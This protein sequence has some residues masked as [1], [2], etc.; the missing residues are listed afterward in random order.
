[1]VNL[2]DEVLLYSDPYGV[3]LVISPWN[4]P[5]QLALLPLASAICGGN[6][7]ILKPSEIAIETSKVLANLVPKY[8][9]NVRILDKF[10]P[11]KKT[12]FFQIQNCYFVVVGGVEETKSLLEQRFDYI[13]FTGSTTVGRMIHHAAN[14][15]LTPVTLELGGKSPVYLDESANI[16]IAVKRILWGKMVN[17]GQT[18]VAPD[19]ILCTK[20]VE[21]KLISAAKKQLLN[22]YG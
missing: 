13:F 9:D 7:C 6:C 17:S 19:Y 3:A 12:I 1:M 21:I 18:C 14:K 16:D 22:F 4:Y 8:L 10:Y 11:K 5:L 2:L 15:Y 20:E